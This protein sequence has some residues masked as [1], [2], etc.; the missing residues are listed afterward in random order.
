MKSPNCLTCPLYQLGA[1]ETENGTLQAMADEQADQLASFEAERIVDTAASENADEIV[2]KVTLLLEQRFSNDPSELSLALTA[3][4]NIYGSLL[5]VQSEIDKKCD[6]LNADIQARSALY[7]EL[8]A[9]SKLLHQE[10]DTNGCEGPG[11][12]PATGALACRAAI[13]EHAKE[14]MQAYNTRYKPA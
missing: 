7:G 8:A 6:A 9:S 14:S 3:L 11:L 13:D 1:Y 4:G 10:V 2:R 5:D 12:L